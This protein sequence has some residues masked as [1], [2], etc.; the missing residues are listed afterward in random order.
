[1]TDDS[2]L[3]RRTEPELAAGVNGQ[4]TAHVLMIVDEP[5]CDLIVRGRTDDRG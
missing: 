4:R 2:N 3:I 1:M 5:G